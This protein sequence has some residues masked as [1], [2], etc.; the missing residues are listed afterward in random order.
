MDNFDDFCQQLV[1][2]VPKLRLW[3]AD[4]LA[5]VTPHGLDE[6]QLTAPLRCPPVVVREILLSRFF[7]D[8][9]I[10][11][12]SDSGTAAPTDGP[13]IKHLQHRHQPGHARGRPEDCCTCGQ[14]VA[15]VL[16]DLHVGGMGECGIF[17]IVCYISCST[18]SNII[19]D[20]IRGI[21]SKVVD[22]II[23]GLFSL[24]DFL[25]RQFH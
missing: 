22:D 21:R 12:F 11:A 2:R 4:T 5:E 17:D 3:A 7:A 16:Q 10:E 19:D 15:A 6:L 23:R 25:N 9:S 8:G 13:C 1:P 20:T 24:F 18:F 14:L